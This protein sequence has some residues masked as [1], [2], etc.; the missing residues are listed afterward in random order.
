MGLDGAGDH[1]SGPARPSLLRIV[2]AWL[3]CPER[4]MKKMCNLTFLA[5]LFLAASL[6]AYAGPVQLNLN[7]DNSNSGQASALCGIPLRVSVAR[8]KQQVEKMYGEP[9]EC[10]AVRGLDQSEKV[11]ARINFRPSDGKCVP[12]ISLDAERG[13]QEIDVTHELEHAQLIAEGFPAGFEVN[14]S[15][16]GFDGEQ[17]SYAVGKFNSFLQH[18]LMYPKMR[19]LGLDPAVKDRKGI[20][21]LILNPKP[22]AIQDSFRVTLN[23][24]GLMID[25]RNDS[26]YKKKT[27]YLWRK[28]GYDEELRKGNQILRSIALANPRRPDQIQPEIVKCLDILFSRRFDSSVL[29]AH[30]IPADGCTGLPPAIGN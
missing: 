7:S 25:L 9:V 15:R 29:R 10:R 12:V 26:G 5:V 20:D 24:V 30:R 16:A 21:A 6:T 28:A 19:M 27:E 8:L 22:P 17:L 13:M 4:Q 11:F 2:I 23:Y 1:S 3:K 18:R 14:P